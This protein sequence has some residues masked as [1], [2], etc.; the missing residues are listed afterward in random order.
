MGLSR[1]QRNKSQHGVH[2][3]SALSVSQYVGAVVRRSLVI[4]ENR[5]TKTVLHRIVNR[6]ALSA[7]ANCDYK[8][9]QFEYRKQEMRMKCLEAMLQEAFAPMVNS[10]DNITARYARMEAELQDLFE[11]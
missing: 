8:N 7:Q 3:Q 2:K 10:I 4:A 11:S 5:L 1:W 6:A 9:Q